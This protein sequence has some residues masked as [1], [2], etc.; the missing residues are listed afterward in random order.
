M[1]E[2]V[3][4]TVAKS[5]SKTKVMERAFRR[6]LSRFAYRATCPFAHQALGKERLYARSSLKSAVQRL[7]AHAEEHMGFGTNICRVALVKDARRKITRVLEA[8]NANRAVAIHDARMY[9]AY[10]CFDGAYAADS[11]ML[12][13]TGV[14]ELHGFRKVKK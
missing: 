10:Q 11:W 6:A 5:I 12:A 7:A 9:E 4:R 13:H 3:R 2:D 14:G 1:S 8:D